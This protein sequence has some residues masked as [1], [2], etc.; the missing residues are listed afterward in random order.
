MKKL[1]LATAIAALS[2]SAAHAAPTVYGKALVT[3]D[4][5]DF[6]DESST[7]LNSTGRIGFKGAEALTANTDVV[8]QL[9]YGIDVDA[10]EGENFRSRDTYIGLSNKQYGTLVAGR[11]SAIDD[12]INYVSQTVGQYD[13]FNAASW[14]GDRV[15]NAMAYFSP[16]YNG[17]QF[18]GMYAFEEDN[19]SDLPTDAEAFGVG[20]KYEPANQPFRA[21]ATYIQSGDFNTTRLSGAY[22]LNNQIGL[23]ALYQIS[24]LDKSDKENLAAVSATYKTAT[25]WTAYAQAEMTSNVGGVD[26][27]DAQRLVLGGKYAFKANATGHVYAGYSNLEQEGQDDRDGF[28]IGTGIE[29]KF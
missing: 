14:D 28:G 11:L 29:Y 20:V 23:G 19:A 8:Y 15:N 12:N 17:L 2:V 25:P 3:V 5:S 22:D 10:D 18:M 21:G 27:K 24:D 9:E 16:A 1:L 4:Y 7:Q 6:D 13:S 26:G